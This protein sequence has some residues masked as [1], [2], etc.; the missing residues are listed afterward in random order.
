MNSIFFIYS[1]RK[2]PGRR[3]IVEARYFNSPWLDL[4]NG[5]ACRNILKEDYDKYIEMVFIIFLVIIC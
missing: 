5:L 1:L 4:L 3:N 2:R